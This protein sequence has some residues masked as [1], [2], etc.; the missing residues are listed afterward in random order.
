MSSKKRFLSAVMGG[1]VDRIPAANAVSIASLGLMDACE[2]AFPETH[3]DSRAMARLAA[4]GH[5]LLGLDTVAPVFSVTQEAAAL[6]C[7]VDWG[8]R[9]VMPTVRTHPFAQTEAFHLPAGW[10]ESPPVQAVLEAIRLLR[11]SIG[12]RAA[13]VGK[14]M[15][16]WTLS[17]HM[18]GAED[19]LVSTLTHPDRARRSLETLKAVP[20]AFACEQIRA[21]ADCI[22][23][24]DHATGGMVS[25]IAYRD[26]LLPIHKEI[27]ESIG[28]PVVLHCCG[29]TADRIRY[30]AE[31]GF[32][33]Y[34]FESQVKISAAREASAGKMSLMGNLNNPELLLSTSPEAVFEAACEAVRAGVDILA[35]ECAVP[36]QTPLDNLK[37]LV[38]A[39]RACG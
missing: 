5:E 7:A 28:S 14:V 13:I 31:A 39:A 22:C 8:R 21:G 3:L 34:H 2:A 10:L 37:A 11:K 6:G 32:D 23:L 27:V 29:N 24:A 36:L 15:G 1:R 35:P 30:F 33:C 12:D 38:R 4:A 9:A 20:V 25:P 18:M 16:P 19:F 17:Y 26:M